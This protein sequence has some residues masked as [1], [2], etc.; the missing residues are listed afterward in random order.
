MWTSLQVDEGD[1]IAFTGAKSGCRSY[2]AVSGGIDVPIVLG[3]RATDLVGKIGGMNGRA[4]QKG[5]KI[6]VFQKPGSRYKRRRIPDEMI[7]DYGREVHVRVVLGPQADAFT[8]EGI[9]TFLSST[10]TVTK[11]VDR[12]GCRLEGPLIQHVESA[13]IISEGIFYGAVQVPKNGQPII[14]LVG[15][16]SIGGYT[17]IG[18]VIAVDL[19]K[20]GQ[21]KPGDRIAFSE[22]PIEEAHDEYRQQERLFRILQS[23][24][25]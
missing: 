8:E 25:S 1:M 19:P 12:M 10:Y 23:T 2:L 20:L 6:P 13:D 11:E 3:S 22:I 21:V 4:L 14:F 5:D 18:G 9:Q 15:R 17:K 7:P 24:C 16:Q